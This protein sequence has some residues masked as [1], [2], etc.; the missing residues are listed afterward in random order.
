MASSNPH[1]WK[2]VISHFPAEQTGL[3]MA[4]HHPPRRKDPGDSNDRVEALGNAV[5]TA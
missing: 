2:T 3:Q 5:I 1:M 4:G